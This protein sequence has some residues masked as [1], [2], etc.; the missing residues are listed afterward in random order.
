MPNGLVAEARA[1]VSGLAHGEANTTAA[2]L[3]VGS[4]AGILLL[5]RFMPKVPSVLVVVVLAALLVNTLDLE[6]HGVDTIGVLPQ[7][8]PP[9]TLPTVSWSEVPPLLLGALAI[10]VVA[11]ADTM[12]TASAFAARKGDRVQ[13][14]PGDDR[15]RCRQHRGRVLPGLPGQHQ[16]LAHCRRRAGRLPVPG[17]RASSA[18]G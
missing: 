8:F 1:F 9:F 16:R 10:A 14:Q 5:N 7:G 4:L 12:S 6:A 18:P 15:H 3:G 17:H 11:L 13:G 2:V